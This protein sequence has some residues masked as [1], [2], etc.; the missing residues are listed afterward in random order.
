MDVWSKQRAETLAKAN[1]RITDRMFTSAFASFRDPDPFSRGRF[2]LWFFNS[3][4][5]CYTFFPFYYG[6]GSPY[7]ISYSNALYTPWGVPRYSPGWH[8]WPAPP[9]TSN[10]TPPSGGSTANTGPRPAVPAAPAFSE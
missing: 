5:G 2:G 3:G 7:G 10:Q 9:N 8:T 6:W 4:I 1:H